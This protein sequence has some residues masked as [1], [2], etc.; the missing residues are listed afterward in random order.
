ML[1]IKHLLFT[2]A[3][4][5]RAS[6]DITFYQV[7]KEAE[8]HFISTTRKEAQKMK[9]EFF[10]GTRTSLPVREYPA[11]R[12]DAKCKSW[13]LGSHFLI[14]TAGNNKGVDLVITAHGQY[15]PWQGDVQIPS[16]TDIIVLGP[17][18]HPLIDPGLPN[19]LIKSLVPYATVHSSGTIYGKVNNEQYDPDTKVQPFLKHEYSQK[20]ITGTP[21]IGRFRN[22]KL[23]KYEDDTDDNYL[24]TR[25]FIE[26]GEGIAIS[27]S[28]IFNRRRTDVLSIRS[29]QLRFTPTLRDVVHALNKAGIRYERIIL[30]FCRSSGSVNDDREDYEAIY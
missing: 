23:Y 4:A 29:R 15:Q 16:G 17:H 5:R 26:L 8:K 10:P 22:Y 28:L 27:Q 30:S 3:L 21:N 13:E 2:F 6:T 24:A 1:E 12:I 11:L 20:S 9:K 7:K 19:L 14:F 18:K 25:G